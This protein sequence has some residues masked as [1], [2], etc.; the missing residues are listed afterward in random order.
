M[1]PPRSLRLLTTLPD[2]SAIRSDPTLI[3]RYAGRDDHATCLRYIVPNKVQ[4]NPSPDIML[5]DTSLDREVLPRLASTGGSIWHVIWVGN[6]ADAT[7]TIDASADKSIWPI[8]PGDSLRV[9]A[10]ADLRA[11]G[12]QLGILITTSKEDTSLALSSPTHGV[13]DF[14][15]HNRR[16]T[17]PM[18]GDIATHRWKITQPLDLSRHH[19]RP[20]IVFSLA[21]DP[22]IASPTESLTLRRGQAVIVDPDQSITVYPSGL[23]YIYTISW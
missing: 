1:I 14:Q 23:A 18:L 17:Y 7:A 20:V 13:D 10:S 11:S 9:P 12:S 8:A 21:G 16:T 6:E 4:P 15:G 19:D 5:V 3:D 22:A 2:A